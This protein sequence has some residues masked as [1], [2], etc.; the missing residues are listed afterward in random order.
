L[1]TVYRRG[2]SPKFDLDF[3]LSAGALMNKILR[4]EKGIERSV[5][6]DSDFKVLWEKQHMNKNHPGRD[7][8]A[9]NI[10]TEVAKVSF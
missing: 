3:T 9:A 8:T 5:F 2:K 6:I 1:L 4:D 7:V 10:E